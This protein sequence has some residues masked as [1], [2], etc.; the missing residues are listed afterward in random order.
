MEGGLFAARGV[1]L[2]ATIA[3]LLQPRCPSLLKFLPFKRQH[4]PLLFRCI[5]YCVLYC[6][7]MSPFW[8]CRVVILAT[9]PRHFGEAACAQMSRSTIEL[10]LE[11]TQL[12][13]FLDHPLHRP[14][15]DSVLFLNC[16]V[17]LVEGL[18]VAR[19][20][21]HLGKKSLLANGEALVQPYLCGDPYPLNSRSI[22]VLI[23]GL[24]YLQSDLRYDGVPVGFYGF[25]SP[26]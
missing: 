2:G 11:H 22:F 16:L 13:K 9:L 21:V 18:S 19:E 15:C 6:I 10:A 24:K 12:D 3:A 17:G 20:R 4:H 23:D 7:S 26:L 5:V 25:S 14:R 8:R 1:S